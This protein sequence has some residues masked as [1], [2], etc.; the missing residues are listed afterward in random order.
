MNKLSLYYYE[1]CPFCK[2]ALNAIT[3]YGVDVELRDVEKNS[4]H[5]A[6]LNRGGGHSQVPCLLVERI[7]G[8]KEWLYEPSQIVQLLRL[9]SILL[10][11]VA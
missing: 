8:Q 7:G 1:S 5:Y 10:L 3:S 6:D 9:R 2:I 4:K 11:K